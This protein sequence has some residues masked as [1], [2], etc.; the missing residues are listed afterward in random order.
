MQDFGCVCRAESGK[1]L[2]HLN[3]CR[4]EKRRGQ[5]GSQGQQG[6]KG[7][8]KMLRDHGSWGNKKQGED[9]ILLIICMEE[10]G[11]LTSSR[12]SKGTR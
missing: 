1:G 2:G 6:P 11:V 4:I 12:H 7:H 9:S 3:T 5:P 10:I 8:S